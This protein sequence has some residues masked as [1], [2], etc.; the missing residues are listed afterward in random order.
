[1]PGTIRLLQTNCLLSINKN[2]SKIYDVINYGNNNNNNNNN[3]KEICTEHH[4]PSAQLRFPAK[5]HVMMYVQK[6]ILLQT[7]TK[8]DQKHTNQH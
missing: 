4:L 7:I 1:M 2:S 5:V 6:Q 8:Q 3:I